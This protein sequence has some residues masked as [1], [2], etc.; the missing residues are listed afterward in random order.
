M[1]ITLIQVPQRKL[2]P[3]EFNSVATDPDNIAPG[4]S[5]IP[6]P[7]FFLLLSLDPGGFKVPD[8]DFITQNFRRLPLFPTSHSSQQP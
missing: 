5:E 4:V 6:D 2:A 1:E 8:L 7:V 3:Y